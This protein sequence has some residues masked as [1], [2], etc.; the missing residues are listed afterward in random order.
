VT[1]SAASL[2]ACRGNDPGGSES[3]T[4]GPGLPQQRP[5][6]TPAA[7]AEAPLLAA[8]GGCGLWRS[9]ARTDALWADV[10]GG[11][12]ENGRRLLLATG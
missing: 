3:R 8:A 10:L 1:S 9:G 5:W 7:A 11:A 2:A 4:S 12:V 6:R